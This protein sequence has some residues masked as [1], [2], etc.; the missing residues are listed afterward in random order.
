MHWLDVILVLKKNLPNF[1][2]DLYICTDSKITPIAI[3]IKCISLSAYISISSLVTHKSTIRAQ[4]LEHDLLFLPA[5]APKRHSVSWLC[6]LEKKVKVN[7]NHI[8]KAGRIFLCWKYD[9]YKFRCLW[10]NIGQGGQTRQDI[11]SVT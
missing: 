10:D 11:I 1:T 5:T 2:S 7:G 4:I 9:I 3:L 6:D 8:Q